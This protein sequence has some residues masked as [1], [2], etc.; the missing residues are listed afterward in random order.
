[1]FEINTCIIIDNNDTKNIEKL[2]K[3]LIS[4]NIEN[5]IVV[6]DKNIKIMITTPTVIINSNYIYENDLIKYITGSDFEGKNILFTQKDF[7]SN[8]YIE[9]DRYGKVINILNSNNGNFTNIYRIKDYQNIDLNNLFNYDYEEAKIDYF[10]ISNNDFNDNKEI[11]NKIELV[12]TSKLKRIED[13][14]PVRANKLKDKIL[15]DNIF[16]VPIIV[17]KDN[18]MILDGHHRFEVAKML[19]FK[20]I[21]AIVVDYNDIS[22][23]TLRKEIPINQKYVKEYVVD[24]NNIYPYKTVKHK[25]PFIIPTISYSLEELYD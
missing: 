20:K 21:P 15:N 11:Y 5:I 25:Y 9:S 24:N 7:N 12:D 18:F 6:K 4:N 13:Y 2:K 23:W 14:N 8:T 19:G 16:S 10:K 17:E 3:Q 1:M 22:V